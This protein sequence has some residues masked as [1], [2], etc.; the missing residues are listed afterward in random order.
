MC[1]RYHSSL[2]AAV[3]T[4]LSVIAL[5]E[6]AQQEASKR[7]FCPS[8]ALKHTLEFVCMLLGGLWA[9]LVNKPH[10]CFVATA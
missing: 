5:K 10:V 6:F 2:H 4:I 9:G 3:S 8:N 7:S 1:G